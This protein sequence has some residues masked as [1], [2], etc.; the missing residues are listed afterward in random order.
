M[1]SVYTYQ[2]SEKPSGCVFRHASIV[3]LSDNCIELDALGV[4]CVV[5]GNHLGRRCSNYRG[6]WTPDGDKFTGDSVKGLHNGL[7]VLNVLPPTA[8][9]PWE[10][11]LHQ[12]ARSAPAGSI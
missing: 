12:Q 4:W 6:I 1:A 5:Q 11:P 2:Q 10:Q 8:Y 9:L 7:V 3:G